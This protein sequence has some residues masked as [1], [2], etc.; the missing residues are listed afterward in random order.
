MDSILPRHISCVE[1]DPKDDKTLQ[2]FERFYHDVFVKAFTNK[3]ECVLYEDFLKCI[4]E[5]RPGE[6]FVRILMFCNDD[7]VIGGIVFD[8][9]DDIKTLTV[10]FIV[11]ASEYQGKGMATKILD[12]T[13]SYIS[14]QYGK[15]IEWIIIEIENPAFIENGDYSYLYFWEKCNM[16]KIDFSYIQPALS[17][18]QSPVKTLMLCACHITGNSETIKIDH[19]KKFVWLYAH[20]AFRIEPPEYDQS[21]KVMFDELDKREGYS[22]SL[23]DLRSLFT[24][25][26]QQF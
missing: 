5:Y 7:D 10:E 1:V 21:I 26:V 11:V 17:P 23:L 15:T 3:D 2:M 6:L 4:N 24:G 8:Y 12:F 16:K 22:L 20:H 25:Y 19:V 18:G 14:C 9:F 13:K